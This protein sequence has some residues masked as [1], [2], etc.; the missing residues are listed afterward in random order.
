[1]KISLKEKRKIYSYYNNPDNIVQIQLASEMTLDVWKNI[2][3]YFSTN[4]ILRDNEI[5][6]LNEKIDETIGEISFKKTRNSKVT[7][8]DNFFKES[9]MDS[10]IVIK[11]GNI[12]FEK[13]K[14]MKPRDK[15]NWFS[16][17]KTVSGT[18][19]AILNEANKLDIKKSIST[20]IPELKGSEWDNIS[21]EQ[22][23]DMATGLDSTEH[24]EKDARM[25]P[26]SGWYRWAVSIGLFNNK[27]GSREN[28]FKVLREMKRVKSAY[29][30]F[31]YNSINT[32]I[33]EMIVE[34][35]SNQPL[36]EIFSELVWSKTG[37]QNDGYVAVTKDFN[38]MGFG[39]ISSTLRDLGRYGMI[40]TP[41][42]DKIT[43]KKIVSDDIIR[44]IQTEGKKEIYANGTVGKVMV[45][46]FHEDRDLSNR[47]QWD[48]V[49]T[50]GDFYK[51]GV[52]GQGL[53]VSPSKDLVIAWF[54]TGTEHHEETMARSIAKELGK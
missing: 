51:G 21:V 8:V 39:F 9:N 7:S 37:M 41:S 36:N 40:F 28:V 31:E 19:I 6:V 23:M 49:F 29:E 13:Y 20:Y 48:A 35:I 30:S 43:H 15:H 38:S 12:T 14:T 54:A 33:L 25:N 18:L 46:S 16:I 11:N 27:D 2:S 52:G 4:Q 42:W 17:G 26:Q 34:N 1:M 53:Y 24:E 3:S 22:T 47:Y 5:S 50:D 32:F 44:S 10:I 45:D